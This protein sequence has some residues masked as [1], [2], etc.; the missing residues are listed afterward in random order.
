[1]N[2]IAKIKR[3]EARVAALE[4]NQR[5]PWPGAVQVEAAESLPAAINPDEQ[6]VSAIVEPPRRKRG[7]PPKS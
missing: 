5:D 7:R 6:I 2:L 1:M 4:E 3:L